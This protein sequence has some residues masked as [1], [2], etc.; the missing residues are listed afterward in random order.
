MTIKSCLPQCYRILNLIILLSL[1]SCGSGN[2]SS[3]TDGS[4]I[5]STYSLTFSINRN[6]STPNR[7]Y[8]DYTSNN[9]GAADI[10]IGVP[11]GTSKPSWIDYGFGNSNNF[12]IEITSSNV[13]EGSHTA[14]IRVATADINGA[15]IDA[16]DVNIT[17]QVSP[18]I[19][20]NPANPVLQIAIGEGEGAD[21]TIITLTQ[22]SNIV[23]PTRI[24]GLDATSWLQAT[25]EGDSIRLSTTANAA[26]LINTTFKL[27]H[28][29]TNINNEVVDI[30]VTLSIVAKSFTVNE[31]PAFFVN[32]DLS[33]SDLSQTLTVATNFS[34]ESDWTANVDVPWL[35]LS[36]I[37]GNTS[38]N[39]EITVS[40]LTDQ[41]A[42]LKSRYYDGD[43]INHRATVTISSP[44]PD[45]ED[46]TITVTLQIDLPTITSV[47]PNVAVSGSNE[48]F[49]ARGYGFSNL[50]T[51]TITC[52]GQTALAYTIINDTDMRITCPVLAA[53]QY[54]IEIVNRAGIDRIHAVLNVVEP[55]VYPEEA[56]TSQGVKTR[57]IYDPLRDALYIA[58]KT[59]DTLERYVFDTTLAPGNQWVKSTIGVNQIADIAM[60]TDGTYLYA[61]GVNENP[62][63]IC[64]S[65]IL[66]KVDLDSFSIAFSS[67][68]GGC[69]TYNSFGFLSDGFM[70]TTYKWSTSV[71][72][73]NP[74]LNRP[75]SAMYLVWPAMFD[76]ITGVS[77]DGRRILFADRNLNPSATVQFLDAS[78]TSDIFSL[79]M[80]NSSL[81][82]NVD[83]IHS[84]RTGSKWVIDHTD[85]YNDAFALVGRLPN[86]T[87]ASTLSHNGLTAYTVDSNNT[88]RKFDLTTVNNG[89]FVEQGTGIT[90]PGIPGTDPVMTITHDGSTLFM[91]GDI[92]LVI[93]RTP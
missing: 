6:G 31:E 56:I 18:E 88:L 2:S 86:S 80:T 1:I 65:P 24:D 35:E 90:L 30:H 76:A 9:S 72:R 89:E 42:E 34:G 14:T 83:S 67:S 87:L 77:R 49:I 4:L 70:A 50:T 29:T 64:P 68:P 91:V 51:Q 39:N 79:N 27:I 81:I 32:E 10:F 45:V 63:I 92:N 60:S 54:E 3:G 17:L 40:L 26:S 13:S 28:V 59:D 73:N 21:S 82:R 62:A 85:I 78:D 20:A 33:V 37:T 41:I 52:G 22:G 61:G 66:H 19:I 16:K 46:K 11:T 36:P 44:L 8:I 7:V 5:L 57:I 84:D 69:K 74:H 53:G 38:T 71:A 75:D 55:V 15:L 47:S 93:M 48:E 25:I 23:T 43:I 12:W 58:N